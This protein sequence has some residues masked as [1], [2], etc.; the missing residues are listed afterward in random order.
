MP[1]L[2]VSGV[3]LGALAVAAI[4]AALMR[5]RAL[6]LVYP[7]TALAAVALGVVDLHVLLG[8]GEATAVLPIGLPTTKAVKLSAEH[9]TI[10][11][12]RASDTPRVGDR[13]E[14]VVGY[15]DTTVHLHEE[16]IGMR[17]GRVEV[18]WR[19]AGRGKI[20]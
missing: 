1:G 2:Y 8:G 19:V 4:L 12:E 5:G 10:E 18:V 17:D 3:A 14:F 7:L 16:M 15:S 13:V 6:A 11:L 20:K 9:S